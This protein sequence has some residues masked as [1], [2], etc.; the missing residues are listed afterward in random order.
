MHEQTIL[1]LKTDL[2]NKAKK[3]KKLEKAIQELNMK[4]IKYESEKTETENEKTLLKD[5]DKASKDLF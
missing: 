1:K 4:F 5:T 3:Q 2:D